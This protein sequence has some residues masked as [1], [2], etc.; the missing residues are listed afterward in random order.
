MKKHPM[1]LLY[2][3]RLSLLGRKLKEIL[4]GKLQPDINL[5]LMRI[6]DACRKARFLKTFDRMLVAATFVGVGTFIYVQ[7]DETVINEP[8]K[9]I[10][11]IERLYQ[12]PRKF[13]IEKTV[14]NNK[15]KI[16]SNLESIIELERLKN[17]A[18][19][20]EIYNI[21]YMIDEIFSA[22]KSSLYEFNR[23]TEQLESMKVNIPANNEALK[24]EVILDS[25]ETDHVTSPSQ[26]VAIPM[27]KPLEL[28]HRHKEL[29]RKREVTS[30]A[31]RENEP[32]KVVSPAD[33]K[34]HPIR[35]KQD[36]SVEPVANARH[37]QSVSPEVKKILAGFHIQPAERGFMVIVPGTDLFVR[38]SRDIASNANSILGPIAKVANFD[39]EFK[40]EIV[41]H[42]DSFKSSTDS[43]KLSRQRAELVKQFLAQELNVDAGRM[44]IDGKGKD[45]PIASNA[46]LD[47]RR[48]NRRIEISFV[49]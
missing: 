29:D 16:I 8:P 10:S 38:N 34:A 39:K 15:D 20:Y 41:G 14:N 17:L 7:L 32:Q 26:H 45:K 46:T 36:N 9:E 21:K 48:S 3:C 23:K 47:G 42:T 37:L 30:T 6:K 13:G 11:N 4:I 27:L 25:G 33:P 24:A 43:R 18:L 40:L 31:N 35:A 1:M 49:R 5:V 2:Q 22:S 19:E 28:A 44:R 12:I